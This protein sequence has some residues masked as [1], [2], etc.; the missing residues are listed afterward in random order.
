M[1]EVAKM[2]EQ[3]FVLELNRQC[4]FWGEGIVG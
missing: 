3:D 1:L 2:D 4:F